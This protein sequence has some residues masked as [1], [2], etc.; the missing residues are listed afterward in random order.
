MCLILSALSSSLHVSR[1]VKV[2][3]DPCPLLTLISF[4]INQKVPLKVFNLL[5]RSEECCEN[6][7]CKGQCFP[8][9]LPPSVQTLKDQCS[10]LHT[11]KRIS[12]LC[13]GFLRT[14]P[15]PGFKAKKF[16]C[17]SAEHF[18]PTSISYYFQGFMKK[19]INQINFDA[20][21]F[22]CIYIL[23][24]TLGGKRQSEGPRKSIF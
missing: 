22:Y 24:G 17:E 8:S 12:F 4:H 23:C 7:Y 19:Y 10:I 3:M 21:L 2:N 13:L 11:H 9:A 18:S 1:A 16:S 6:S 15:N 5:T 14:I 20:F